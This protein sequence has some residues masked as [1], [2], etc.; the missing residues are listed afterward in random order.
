MFCV[1]TAKCLPPPVL[2]P[3]EVH[4]HVSCTWFSDLLTE[5]QPTSSACL[6]LL[7]MP[8]HGLPTVSDVCVP[9]SPDDDAEADSES[10]TL[11]PLECRVAAAAAVRSR[12]RRAVLAAAVQCGLLLAALLHCIKRCD[13]IYSA[14]FR[15]QSRVCVCVSDGGEGR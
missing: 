13:G 6:V 15:A 10:S 5:L 4:V 12:F 7:P 9:P 14:S 2:T 3:A 8:A 11:L 1:Y